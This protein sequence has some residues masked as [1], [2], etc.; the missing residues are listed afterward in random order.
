MEDEKDEDEEALVEDENDEEE[1]EESEDASEIADKPTIETTEQKGKVF[2]LCP[3]KD[4]TSCKFKTEKLNALYGHIKFRHEAKGEFLSNK[5]QLIK[6]D[7][8]SVVKAEV[9]PTVKPPPKGR[10][11]GLWT[12]EIKKVKKMPD[13]DEEGDAPNDLGIKAEIKGKLRQLLKAIATADPDKRD[14]LMPEREVI[15][16]YIKLLAKANVSPNEISSIQSRYDDS[17]LPEVQRVLGKQAV[18]KITAATSEPSTPTPSLSSKMSTLSKV[19][20]LRGKVKQYLT[21]IAKLTPSK[22]DELLG[23]RESLIML[24]KRLAIIDIPIQELDEMDEL[25]EGEVRPTV[26]AAIQTTKKTPIVDKDGNETSDMMTT[27]ISQ[28]KEE[29]EMARM[30]RMLSEE[31]LRHRQSLEAMRTSGA[32]GSGA[33]APVMRPMMDEKG[34]IKRDEKGN[35]VMETTYVPVEQGQG[36]NQL[37]MTMML[38]GKMGNNDNNA[39]LAMI[40]D[41]NTKLLTAMLGKDSGKSDKEI[42]LEVQNQN[43]K[44][45]MDFNGKMMELMKNKGEDPTQTQ[46]REELRASRDEQAK[47]RD[48]MWQQQMTYMNKEME[49]LKRY[50]YRD[51]L[52]TIQ[53]QKE[54]LEALGIVS[55]HQKDSESRA[56]EESSKL[57]KEAIGKADKV[58]DNMNN[59]VQPFANAQAE[60]MKAQINQARPLR[61]AMNEREKTS[62]YRQ[63]LKNIEA[64]EGGEEPIEEEENE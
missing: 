40:M 32:T 48:L 3:Y 4:I 56:L 52:E 43:M 47:T 51:D 25:F 16:D 63:I 58:L 11:R 64:E 34:Q 46:I 31:Q 35:P 42:I 54:R 17:L 18:D 38:S 28:K 5:G 57:A 53:K 6:K 21:S 2:H 33:M 23:E 26:D 20:K 61:K 59:L 39:L 8:L 14:S 1:E 22:R 30:D 62:A 9:R 10:P 15:M 37:L 12:K 60:I 13:D 29:L 50:A 19:A 7:M 36:M 49:D 27:H 24:N 45:M 41:N 55:S 44:M